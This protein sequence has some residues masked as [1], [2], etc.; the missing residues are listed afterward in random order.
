FDDKG[1]IIDEVEQPYTARPGTPITVRWKQSTSTV[2]GRFEIKAYDV[3]GFWSGIESVTFVNIPHD[4]IIFA[5]GKWDLPPSQIGKLKKPLN[6]IV[7]E[8]RKVA[9]VL[10]MSLYVAGYTDTVGAASDNVEL[11]RKRAR[12]IAVWFQKKGLKIPIRYQGFGESALFV[13]TPDNTDEARNRRAVYVLSV[14]PPPKSSAFP[15]S[16]WQHVGSKR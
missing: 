8:L 7:E 12:S 13:K 15:R 3:V 14:L 5:S 4:D 1:K 6:R 10:P 2:T 11:S 16:K 9:G